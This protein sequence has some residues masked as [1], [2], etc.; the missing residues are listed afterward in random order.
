MLPHPGDLFE[1]KYRIDHVLGKG[2][3]AHVY[4]AVV[5]EIDR[6]VAI[7]ILRPH[8][9]ADGN[10]TYSDQLRQ[11]FLREAKLLSELQDPHTIRLYDY[12]RSDEGLLF[13]IFE[14]IDGEPLSDVIRRG[15]MAP[16]RV[17]HILTQVLSGLREAHLRGII[18]R[19]IK[20]A[21][22]MI[23]DYLGDPDRAKL[24]DF[25]VAKDMDASVQLTSRNMLIGT[26]RYM[27][28]EQVRG[29][30]VV[31]ASDLY[32][33][34][35]VAYEM[36]VGGKAIESEDMNIVS[37]FHLRP[38]SIEIPANVPVPSDLRELVNRMVTKSLEWRYGSADQALSDLKVADLEAFPSFDDD[39]APPTLTSRI[40]YEE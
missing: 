2:S 20:P 14:F 28:P 15:R 17:V 25:G 40:P 22:I 33:L 29:D 1:R 39:D 5:E 18:H 9:D 31:P 3:F 34:G 10:P 13:M 30:A 23:Y 12:G 6:K 19:D 8:Y 26:M 7:K 21:N 32:S 35:L 24:L 36:L 37:L 38:E 16:E 27:S 11:R 4:K